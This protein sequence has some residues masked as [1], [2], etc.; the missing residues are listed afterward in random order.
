ARLRGAKKGL[1]SPGSKVWGFQ[2]DRM[3]HEPEQA[4]Q[5]RDIA[6]RVLAGESLR[7]A[8]L[9]Y[10]KTPKDVKRVLLAPRMIGQRGYHATASGTKCTQRADC[11]GCVF[12][13]AAWEPILDPNTFEALRLALTAND[14]DKIGGV[15]AIRYLLTGFVYC[16][17][18][19]G[20]CFGFHRTR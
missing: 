18:C 6:R 14:R 12:F 2:R 15:A 1:P 8:S 17:V 7:S 9:R 3:T 5:I 16:G 10:G 11:P 4:A 19:K 20:R 13:D